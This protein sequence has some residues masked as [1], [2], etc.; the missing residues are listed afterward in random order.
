MKP[1]TLFTRALLA[2]SLIIGINAFANDRP[3]QGVKIQMIKTNEAG[4]LFQTRLVMKALE[5]LGYD[6]L[7][8]QEM[9]HPLMYVSLANGDADIFATHW[10]PLHSDYYKNGGGD[11]KYFKRGQ[12]STA[13]QGYLIDKKTAEAHGI[14]NIAQLKDPELAKLFDTDGDGKAD[15]I[16]CDP[17]WGCEAIIEH[18][19]DAYGLRNNIS[20]R[21]GSYAVLIA[22]VITRFKAGQP[23]LYY[24][25]IPLWPSSIMKPGQDVVW[26]EVPFSALPGGRAGEDTTLANGKNYGFSMNT[27]HI[28]V[29][30]PFAEAHPDVAKLAEVMQLPVADITAQ[31]ALMA[32]GQ[33]TAADVERHTNAWIRAHQATF[34]GWLEQAR[35]AVK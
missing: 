4:E 5:Q 31:N 29:S 12:Y 9:S 28:V 1:C 23:V 10:E 22:D 18:Q 16:G 3:G 32:E 20:H 25:W 21:Q 19:L 35:A 14:S 17:G 27:Q 33:N 30:R 2:F 24:T 8:H 34:D 6:V 7:P 11:S 26:L 13:A 15:L